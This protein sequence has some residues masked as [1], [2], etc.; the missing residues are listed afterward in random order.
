MLD[1]E[2]TE[3]PDYFFGYSRV[4]NPTF[5][6]KENA[7]DRFVSKFTYFYKI[8]QL[9]RLFGIYKYYKMYLK[10]K[11]INVWVLGKKNPGRT[12]EIY[13]HTTQII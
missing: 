12:F 6:L 2:E 1:L 11:F 9:K 7:W 4:P 8:T 10:Y 5:F 13:S 3:Y